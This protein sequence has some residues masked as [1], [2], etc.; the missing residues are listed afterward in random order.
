MKQ[1]T[2]LLVAL[3][4]SMS[5]YA[6]VAPQQQLHAPM[7]P[8]PEHYASTATAKDDPLDTTTPTC[9]TY[10][11]QT[12]TLSSFKSVAN[13]LKALPT[14]KGEYETSAAF[15]ARV[16][17][18]RG[19]IPETVI[20]QGIF[21]AEYVT[22]DADAGVLKVQAY[23]LQNLNTDY[24]D[25]FGYGSTYYEK[26]KYSS[27]GN[28]DVVVFQSETPTGSYVA[29]NA[30]GAK[31]TVTKMGRLQ[32]AIFEGE[33][34][35]YNEDLFVDQAPG[36]EA[37]LGTVPMTIPEAQALKA[38]GKVAFVVKPKWPFYAEGIHLWDATVS[39]PLEVNNPIQ[40]IV[41]DIQC[42][43]LLTRAN[44]VVAAYATR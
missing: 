1:D 17:A 22:Y 43:L 34:A 8:T 5:G 25:V 4:V 33:Q 26:V 39:N 37:M 7:S 10:V 35:R 28:R 31:T 12:V 14:T 29:S 21:S 40:V 11:G 27:L 15:E 30:F 32:Q 3:C 19:T 41:G 23:A 20:I 24:S 16:A 2:M 9:D 36:V 18:A 6:T 13:T 44:K 38:S 42:G